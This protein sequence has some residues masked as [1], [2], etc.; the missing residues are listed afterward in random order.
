MFKFDL[1][2]TIKA[3][4]IITDSVADYLEKGITKTKVIIDKLQADLLAAELAVEKA[5]RYVEILRNIIK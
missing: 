2:K 1:T 5:E 3:V 4:D